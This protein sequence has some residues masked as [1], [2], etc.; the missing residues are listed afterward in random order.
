MP[1]F[2]DICV[3]N[4]IW[5]SLTLTN[6]NSKFQCHKKATIF[7]THKKWKRRHEIN[8]S[9][10]TDQKWVTEGVISS[11][12]IAVFNIP[13]VCWIIKC[14]LHPLCGCSLNCVALKSHQ[15]TSNR[16]RPFTAHGIAFVWHCTWPNLS[17]LKRFLQ[18]L[19]I[20]QQPDVWTN[21]HNVSMKDNNVRN[22]F[23]TLIF[24][25]R[26]SWMTNPCVPFAL[27][28]VW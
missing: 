18:F 12:Y 2:W 8:T 17:G 23:T 25:Y 28:T 14:T 13:P 4:I 15:M 24:V 11:P 26:S 20:G 27:T 5:W 19:H 9:K 7:Y 3:S 1:A 21:L 10:R 16:A 6:I 22:I